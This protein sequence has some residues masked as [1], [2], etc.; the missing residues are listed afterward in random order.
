MNGIKMCAGSL[1]WC[2]LFGCRC[3][4]LRSRRVF[5]KHIVYVNSA[6]VEHVPF[7][8]DDDDGSAT[9]SD[10]GSK[11][12]VKKR[13]NGGERGRLYDWED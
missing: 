9:D 13:V 1:Q 11:V 7:P 4:L 5:G 3:P 6:P 2:E 10:S 12:G 8:V